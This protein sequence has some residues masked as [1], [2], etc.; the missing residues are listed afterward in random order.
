V[1]ELLEVVS[2]H[3]RIAE[4]SRQQ[5]GRL[6]RQ[7][8]V[9]GVG[10]AHDLRQVC[11]RLRIEPQLVDH[12]VERA[13]S[14]T[15]RPEHALDVERRGLEAFGDARHLGGRDEQEH[16]V[17]IDE[18]A[19]QPRA[20]DPVDLGPRARDPHRALLGIAGWELGGDEQR[21]GRAPRLDA[22]VERLGLDPEL[23]QPRGDALAQALSVLAHH[24]DVATLVAARPRLDRR[25]VA[26]D[27]AGDDAGIGVEVLGAANVDDRGCVGRADQAG[28]LLSGDFGG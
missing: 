3:A 12:G 19:D 24:H 10:G 6:G 9:G 15:M 11:E 5:P 16:R 21:A 17:G 23:P 2:V 14:L 22:A 25:R 13:A 4:R 27:R 1:T 28:Q 8:H 7:I 26:A 18:P 20:R